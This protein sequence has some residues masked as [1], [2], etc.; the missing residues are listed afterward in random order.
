MLFK[1]IL[2]L[3]AMACIL[4][5][6]LTLALIHM[7]LQNFAYRTDIHIFTFFVTAMAAVCIAFLTAG[8]H[9]IRVAR[10]SPVESLRY[11]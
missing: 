1:E 5:V 8:Y 10:A 7:W 9:C 2:Y 3:M 4:A 11:E 6:P